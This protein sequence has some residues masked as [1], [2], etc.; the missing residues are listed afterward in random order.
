MGNRTNRQM[1]AVRRANKEFKNVTT[2]SADIAEVHFGG[3]GEDALSWN[4][5]LKGPEDT[6]YEGAEF[7][8]SF[9]FPGDYPF[10]APKVTFVIPAQ[11]YHPNVNEEGLICLDILKSSYSPAVSCPQILEAIRLL[12]QHPST[13]APLRAEVGKQ[14]TDDQEAF[15]QAAMEAWQNNSP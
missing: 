10:K 7:S 13:D 5:L 15:E 14:Y 8:L 3:N 6:C 9:S 1:A 12:L 11:I 2:K 4:V